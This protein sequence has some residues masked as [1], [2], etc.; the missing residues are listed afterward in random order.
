MS[1]FVNSIRRNKARS[2][3]T[4]GIYK[5]IAL[6]LNLKTACTCVFL[7]FFCLCIY[8]YIS[9]HVLSIGDWPH[10]VLTTTYTDHWIQTGWAPSLGMVPINILDRFDIIVCDSS[11]SRYVSQE[12]WKDIF[13]GYVIRGGTL[14]I[15]V[16]K[17]ENL[18]G[19]IIK[20]TVLGHGKVYEVIGGYSKNFWEELY[21]SSIGSSARLILIN[22]LPVVIMI[23]VSFI[24]IQLVLICIKSRK[25]SSMK[26]N[27]DKENS[28]KK[29]RWISIPCRRKHVIP[30]LVLFMLS[31]LI[32]SGWLIRPSNE[33]VPSFE[34][35]FMYTACIDYY[36]NHLLQYG[37][38]PALF[39][40]RTYS[41]PMD[42]S[43]YMRTPALILPILFSLLLGKSLFNGVIAFFIFGNFMSTIVIYYLVYRHTYNILASIFSATLY[44]VTNPLLINGFAQ[45]HLS[46][47]TITLLIPLTFLATYWV[48]AV[49]T[50]Q[51]CILGIVLTF[52]FYIWF[53]CVNAVIGFICLLCSF[54]IWSCLYWDKGQ[55]LKLILIIIII[56]SC[57][58]LYLSFI[59][60]Y[61]KFFPSPQFM[62]SEISF[63]EIPN[64]LQAL[65]LNIAQTN[66]TDPAIMATGTIYI[67]TFIRYLPLTF[68]ILSI[69]ACK[70]HVVPFF[71][72][73]LLILSSSALS[74]VFYWF[75]PMPFRAPGRI[76]LP[77]AA[78]IFA[79][80]AGIGFSWFYSNF[81]KIIYIP[82]LDNRPPIFSSLCLMSLILVG[83]LSVLMPNVKLWEIPDDVDQAYRS[84]P[85]GA[86]I[87][88]IPIYGALSFSYSLSS[89]ELAY[90]RKDASVGWTLVH[91]HEY[92]ANKYQ[93]KC[94][95]GGTS[96]EIPFMT[97]WWLEMINEKMTV[98][99]DTIGAINA[100]NLAPDLQYLVV[101]K[102]IIPQYVL[103]QL[104]NSNQL[105][106]TF[107]SETM[108]VYKRTNSIELPVMESEK[109]FLLYCGS[110]RY[111]LP[112]LAML[113]KGKIPIIM[114]QTPWGLFNLKDAE[115]MENLIFT[116]QNTFTEDI[117][118]EYAIAN[119]ENKIFI[120]LEDTIKATETDWVLSG[121]WQP[122]WNKYTLATITP[123]KIYNI[124]FKLDNANNYDIYI[125][126]T[127]NGPWRGKLQVWLNHENVSVISFPQDSYGFKWFNIGT[128]NLTLGENILG[129]ENIE[130]QWI[131]IDVIAIVKHEEIEKTITIY[132]NA[133]RRLIAQKDYMGIYEAEN[134]YI[135]LHEASITDDWNKNWETYPSGGWVRGQTVKLSPQGYM[136][137]KIEAPISNEY[138]VAV[139]QVGRS[140]LDING[141]NISPQQ[142]SE[143]NNFNY[144]FYRVFLNQG[145][146]TI[147]FTALE[148]SVW[149][150]CIYISNKP[151]QEILKNENPA[152][153]ISI[154]NDAEYAVTSSTENPRYILLIKSY[155][156]MWS[157]KS[158]SGKTRSYLA[159]GFL[160]CFYVTGQRYEII[161]GN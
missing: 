76:F 142:I 99:N 30:I 18:P 151:L 90:Y 5:L 13:D 6:L 29:F 143:L 59:L 152:T 71:V 34:E 145:M 125:R 42:I 37:S 85:R 66:R 65:E 36:M 101:Y 158:S 141:Q 95:D 91:L 83:S 138:Y 88:M 129:L 44:L 16:S 8:S 70:K 133:I 56:A 105:E 103:E 54:V 160:T 130:S 38:I 149:I 10:D 161:F 46:Y 98:W 75:M 121:F 39:D 127:C 7:L 87:I 94:A 64:L 100:L 55:L 82:K 15:I 53:L 12:P 23:L 19:E 32:F 115:N 97:K 124:S 77:T 21:F 69:I 114:G 67:Y 86:R 123:G 48:F 47:V 52:L 60:S 117:A 78:L 102:K 31:V 119:A 51:V 146:Q 148:E 35:G 159:N 157:S 58:A 132:E 154:K 2:R 80:L 134:S 61:A 118:I 57:T 153:T 144:L 109:A 139:K 93:L 92:M 1:N 126:G 43:Y 150:D 136:E 106:K 128:F 9:I 108:A 68:S 33:I 155:F 26:C 131:D 73:F 28:K 120:N 17:N 3:G 63:N 122:S 22:T 110:Y 81:S 72:G 84:I 96:W 74:I 24:A 137:I 104:D 25:E 4:L 89:P 41:Q 112:S 79:F 107:D 45:G 40:S 11:I 147:K 156:G 111:S 135:K 50:K 49:K 27:S 14:V 140:I 20:E 113:T 116:T 62:L